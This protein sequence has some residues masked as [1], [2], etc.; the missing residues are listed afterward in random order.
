VPLPE[1][2]WAAAQAEIGR[3]QGRTAAVPDAELHLQL[4]KEYLLESSTLM[5]FNNRRAA[6]LATL[7]QAEASLAVGLAKASA[8]QD[9]LAT[10]RTNLLLARNGAAGE[11]GVANAMAALGVANAMPASQGTR[12]IRTWGGIKGLAPQPAWSPSPVTAP[13]HGKKK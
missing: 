6:T 13:S 11:G 5:G 1:D 7:A 3:A 9:D 2:Q 12:A 10:L 4:A 8:A